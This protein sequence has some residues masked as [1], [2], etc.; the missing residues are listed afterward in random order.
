MLQTLQLVV[1][2]CSSS[3][4]K[5]PE[6]VGKWLGFDKVSE[7]IVK[8]VLSLL[9]ELEDEVVREDLD[10]NLSSDEGLWIP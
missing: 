8:Q 3:P 2:G 9:E 7:S 4:N 10:I 6:V 5:F 1:L